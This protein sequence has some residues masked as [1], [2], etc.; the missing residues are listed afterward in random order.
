[1]L[2]RTA[3]KID[4]HQTLLLWVLSRVC[5]FLCG[6]VK[7]DLLSILRVSILFIFLGF[8]GVSKSQ[9]VI[10]EIGIAPSNGDAGGGGEYI[11]LFN[12]SG[13]TVNIS[14]YVLAFSGVTATGSAGWTVTIPSGTMLTSGQYYLIGGSGSN[15]LL[16]SNWTSASG[17]SNTWVNSYGSFGSNIATL[18]IGRAYAAGK[19]IVIGNLVNGGGQITLFNSTGNVVSRFTYGTGNNA[20][21]YPITTNSSTGCI[22]NNIPNPGDTALYTNTFSSGF[23]Q[24][25]Y[26]NAG[27]TYSEILTSEPYTPG[28]P[29]LPNNANGVG[30]QIAATSPPAANVGAN[31]G[32]CI[33]ASTT[34]G[35]TAVVGNTYSW[36]SN[37]AGFTSSASSITVSPSTTTTYTLT[38]TNASGC[39]NSN[40]VTVNLV[41]IPA[42]NAGADRNITP[43]SIE[44]IGSASVTG[45][46][47]EWTSTPGSTIPSVSNPQVNPGVTTT[48][49][50]KET[51]SGT[52]CSNSN[53]VTLRLAACP[54]IST[55]PI[56]QMGCIG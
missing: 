4:K 8:S 37:P 52:E 56:S 34:L 53:N 9:I 14:C 48:Y 39:T 41:A 31:K 22:L 44:I 1:M 50:L 16:N 36:T 13:C 33:G 11:E 3:H 10:N 2:A 24:G 32:I 26:L 46:S 23:R 15:F 19:R 30:T 6:S 55:Q 5:A 54:V 21:T 17:N 51:V 42:A 29:G 12:K 40:S 18:D 47:Y 28:T 7:F 27:G 25:V 49:T 35:S 38:E 45:H 43:G 20:G